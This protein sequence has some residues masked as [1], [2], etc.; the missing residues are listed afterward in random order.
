MQ[1]RRGGVWSV[2]YS[3]EGDIEEDQARDKSSTQRKVDE[4]I[5]LEDVHKN[6]HIGNR[7]QMK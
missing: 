1:W 7:H 5:V 3:A 6:M 2:V 4:L